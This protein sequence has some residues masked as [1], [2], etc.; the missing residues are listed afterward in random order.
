MK[1]RIERVRSKGTSKERNRR[2]FREKLMKKRIER[3]MP[4]FLPLYGL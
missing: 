1:K 3:L 4:S 2:S